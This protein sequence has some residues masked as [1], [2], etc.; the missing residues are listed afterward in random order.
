M[1]TLAVIFF[2]FL[3][4]SSYTAEAMPRSARVIIPHAPH[5]VTQR[6]NRGAPT[7]LGDGDF[8]FYKQLLEDHCQRAGVRVWAYCLMPNH[9]HLVLVPSD[10]TGLSKALRS[11]HG[12]YSQRINRREGWTGHLWQSRFYSFAMHDDHLIAA[13]RYVEL[14]PVRARLVNDAADWRWS[15]ANAHLVG[16]DDGL[17]SVRP[18]LDEIGDWRGFLDAGQP[19]A[20]LVA[21]RH[22][23]RTGLPQGSDSFIENLQ[24]QIGRR[25]KP[26]QRGRQRGFRKFK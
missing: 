9:V 11:V 16:H 20:E 19:E 25:L 15:S 14:N 10:E 2:T 8:L 18:L 17:V 12:Q 6:G 22:H 4:P 3:R 21:T 24:R 23:Q 13:V 5:H 1:L 7:F 26:G